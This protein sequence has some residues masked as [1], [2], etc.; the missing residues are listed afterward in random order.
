VILLVE[1][2]VGVFLYIGV[3]LLRQQASFTLLFILITV[4]IHV[5]D[6]CISIHSNVL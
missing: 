6:Q 2:V 1:V 4:A 3:P 5:N